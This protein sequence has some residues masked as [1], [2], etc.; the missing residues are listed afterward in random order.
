VTHFGVEQHRD[1]ERNA[2]YLSQVVASAEDRAFE[3]RRAGVL[4]LRASVSAD[5][6]LAL[7]YGF[8]CLEAILLERSTMDNVLSRLV[9]AVAYRVGTSPA[10][11][12]QLRREVKQLYEIRS[13]YVHTGD[14]GA[15]AWLRPRERCLE[16]AA[17]VLQREIKE[18]MA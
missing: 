7:T 11:R 8:M 3:L 12:T 4:L 10:H 16:I 9:E 1:L 5:L 13:R 17:N 6:G 14:A 15:S 2:G 18:A